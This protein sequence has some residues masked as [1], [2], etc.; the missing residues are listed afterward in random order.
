MSKTNLLAMFELNRNDEERIKKF[1]FNT[2][3]REVWQNPPSI[4]QRYNVGLYHRDAIPREGQQH[5]IYSPNRS[6]NARGLERLVAKQQHPIY[7]PNR[8]TTDYERLIADFD[9][10]NFS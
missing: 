10:C 9:L 7:S 3:I 8:S 2:L 1:D 5:H 4:E 6:A